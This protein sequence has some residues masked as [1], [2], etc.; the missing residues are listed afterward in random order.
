MPDNDVKQPEPAGQKNM[1]EVLFQNG[2]TQVGV[3][4]G[5]V[6]AVSQPF[7]RAEILGINP[8]IVA[9]IV[10]CLL[11]IYQI[12]LV[13]KA[14]IG[15]CVILVPI[16]AAIMFSMSLGTNNLVANLRRGDQPEAGT[17]IQQ[18]QIKNRRFRVSSG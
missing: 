15:E 12:R 17:A 1:A 16:V 5:I 9:I 14:A 18:V 11:A 2:S 3:M 8:L 13:Q 4:V 7:A 10:S 6:A